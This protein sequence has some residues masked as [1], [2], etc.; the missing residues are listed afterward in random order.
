MKHNNVSFLL[1]KETLRDDVASNEHRYVASNE[2]RDVAS[3]E[4]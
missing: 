4:H 1:A 3:N 2:H